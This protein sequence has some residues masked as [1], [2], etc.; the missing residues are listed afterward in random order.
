MK[1]EN[2]SLFF[3]YRLSFGIIGAIPLLYCFRLTG[4]IDQ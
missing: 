3:H 1:S 4:K 2:S